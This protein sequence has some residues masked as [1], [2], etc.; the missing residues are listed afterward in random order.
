MGTKFT[1][2]IPLVVAVTC[3][4]PAVNDVDARRRVSRMHDRQTMGASPVIFKVS[5]KKV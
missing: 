1:H 2:E 4:L 5:D 3:T